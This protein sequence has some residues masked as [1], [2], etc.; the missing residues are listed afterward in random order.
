MENIFESKSNHIMETELRLS[1]IAETNLEWFLCIMDFVDRNPIF[2]QYLYIASIQPT[3]Q[4]DIDFPKTIKKAILYYIC[5]A[6]VKSDFGR[7]LW[8]HIYNFNTKE[9]IL[10]STLISPKKK[11]YL[12]KAIQIPDT[13]TLSDL[14]KTKI[15]G[16]GVSGIAFINKNFSSINGTDYVEYTDRHFLAGIQKIYKLKSRPTPKEALNIINTWGENKSVGNMF[17]IQVYNYL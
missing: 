12:S 13:F 14:N 4:K 17:C 15:A 6:G 9:E 11:E 16:I 3:S 8:L 1:Y 5:F 2:K 10:N 7:K